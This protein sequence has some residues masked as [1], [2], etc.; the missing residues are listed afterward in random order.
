[1]TADDQ[2]VRAPAARQ[3]GLRGAVAFPVV[4]T[5]ALGVVEWYPRWPEELDAGLRDVLANVGSQ[6]GQFL[7]RQR[8]EQERGRSER[9]LADFFDN[10]T[11]GLHCVGP[12]GVLLRV[13]QA[14]LDMLGYT[15]EEYLGRS[16]VE[17][18]VD[19]QVIDDMLARLGRGEV[20]RDQPARLRCK[21]GSIKHVRIDSSVFRQEGRFLH[22]RC[23][24][25]DVTSQQRV[26]AA[27]S[28][29]REWLRTTLASIG[30]A[31]V[32]TDTAG[33][34]T[35]LNPVA[36]AL[37]GWR[38]DEA[39]GQALEAVCPLLCEQPR[40][41]VENP[42][43][44]VL[45]HG[46]RVALANHTVLLARNGTEYP[47]DHH[48]APIRDEHGELLGAVLVLR[49]ASERRPPTRRGRSWRPSSNRR[50]TR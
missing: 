32:A 8:A 20:L 33:C 49:D 50:R 45:R 24:T 21:D 1:M 19:R 41:P 29:Q 37:T 17:F 31:I 26:E 46:E 15:R 2:F 27:L 7:D 6:V 14:E 30:D 22:T 3:A 12:D 42:V 18:H 48:A 13:N 34:I 39:V 16:I 35:F 43:F 38:Q 44:R 11:V 28:Q 10:A 40:G 5:E 25:R 9:D 23:I 36:E 4:G 47:V